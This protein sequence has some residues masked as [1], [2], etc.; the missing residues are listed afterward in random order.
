M[1]QIHLT[2]FC[3]DLQYQIS[4]KLLSGVRYPSRIPKLWIHF[5]Q[6]T[7]YYYSAHDTTTNTR[8]QNL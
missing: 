3:T 2:I 4:L 1:N 7:Y 6:C 8:Q 5:T